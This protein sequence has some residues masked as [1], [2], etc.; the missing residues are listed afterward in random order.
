M[1]I[2]KI[3]FISITLIVITTT[4]TAQSDYRLIESHLTAITKTD[5]YRHY[6]NLPVLNQVAEYIY[7]IFGQYAD[8]VYYQKYN[9]EGTE[10]KNV[11]CRFGTKIDK[12]VMVI[13]AH[14]DV[15]GNQE[16]ADD[17]ASGVVGV[18][19]LARLLHGKD[20]SRPIEL[21]AYTLE[22]P[23]FFRT[24]Q[25][26]SY[27]HAKSLQDAGTPVYGMAAIEMIGYFDDE[28]GSQDYPVKPLK[29]VY[30]SKADYILLVK[31]S[32]YGDFVEN[33]SSW[34]GNAKTIKTKNIKAPA[35]LQGIDFSDH[36]N[37]WKLG[38]DAMMVT[39]T[40]F[41]RNKNYH[42]TTD[43]MATLDIGR[44]AGVINAIYHAV[45]H[46]DKQPESKKGTG[47][48]SKKKSSKS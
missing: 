33:F 29:V 17:N 11:V 46:I 41:Y 37:Y 6:K 15:C 1:H 14:Y 36:L 38:F 32:G 35:K 39:N 27:V 47:K 43:V 25:M 20:V 18:L 34:F 22:E 26:G 28:S 24:P 13:G 7:N 42:Q 9:V 2:L 4:T 21:V 45:L 8:T 19:E 30:G 23:P 12:P 31:K 40:A 16:G 10:Y 3:C 44:M 48:W 5:G